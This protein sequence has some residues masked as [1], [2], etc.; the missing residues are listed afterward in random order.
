MSY[1]NLD[2]FLNF[3]LL[4]A[5][6]GEPVRAAFAANHVYFPIFGPVTFS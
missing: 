4:S 5:V 1:F 3:L 6:S 2:A